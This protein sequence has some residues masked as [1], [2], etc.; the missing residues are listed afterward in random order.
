MRENKNKLWVLVEKPEVIIPLGR[1]RRRLEDNIKIDI[2]EMA[3][4]GM[5]WIKVAQDRDW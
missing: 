2:K 4:G 3:W 1:P 5:A